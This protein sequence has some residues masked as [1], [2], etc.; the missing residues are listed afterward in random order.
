M[1]YGANILKKP[2]FSKPVIRKNWVCNGIAVALRRS[3][4]G[5]ICLI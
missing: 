5:R 2:A 3:D 1:M 4:L